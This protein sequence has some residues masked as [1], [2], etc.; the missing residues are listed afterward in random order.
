MDGPEKDSEEQFWGRMD[1]QMEKLRTD[2]SAGTF[3]VRIIP[4]PRRYDIVERHGETCYLD[5]YVGTLIPQ[6]VMFGKCA[7]Q[8]AG[9]P[10]YH[11]APRIESTKTYT[12]ARKAALDSELQGGSYTE[13]AEKAAPHRDLQIGSAAKW[14]VFLSVDICGATA[15]RRAD[16]AAFDAAYALFLRELGTAVGLF[17]GTFLKTT[18]DGFIAYIDHP[19]FTR[20]CDNAID[21]GLGLLAVLHRSLNPALLEARLPPLTVRIGADYGS[22]QLRQLVIPATGFS[23]PEIGSDALNRA[24]KIQETAQENEFRIGRSLYELV[25]VEWLERALE[26]PFDGESIGVPGYKAYRVA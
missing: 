5:K 25:H 22:V 10:I 17:N 3:E 14:L 4:D 8:M 26:V 12:E 1:F 9:L 13:P 11:L 20:Q 16:R 2:P 24:V 21:M 23:V 19:S 7:E 15:L 18:G 6:S